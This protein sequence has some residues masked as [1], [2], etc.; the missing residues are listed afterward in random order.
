MN[1]RQIDVPSEKLHEECG[2]F[3]MY[4]NDGFNTARITYAG[5]FALQHRGQESSGIAINQNREITLY[6]N[7]GLVQEVFTNDIL[8]KLKGRMAI[9][10][11]RYS[12]TGENSILNAQPL[13]SRYIKG[14]LAMAANGNLSNYQE[15]KHRLELDGAIF[16]TT[17][18]TEIIMH[19]L[20]RARLKTGRVE[21]ALAEVMKDLKG[22]YSLIMMSPQK[23][24]ACRDP[25]GMRPLCIGKIDNSFV[26]AS[27]TCALD[28]VRAEF[29]REIDPGEVVIIDENGMRSI[30]DNCGDPKK[31]QIC[32]F[33]YI[34]FA[35]SDS[36]IEGMSVHEAR[37]LTGKILAETYR[38]DADLVAGVPDSGVDAAIGYAQASGIPY[39]KALVINRYVG[40]TFIQ[41]TQ[42]QRTTAVRL[43]INVLKDTVKGKRIVL[44]DDSI[45]RGTTCAKLVDMLKEA[46][47]KE[48]H[49]R[50]SSPPFVWPCYFGTDIPSKDHLLACHYSVEEICK[51]IG[52]D[53]LGFLP[54]ERLPEIVPNIR[55]KFCDGCFT[56]KY[57]YSHED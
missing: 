38:V 52:A 27:E 14:Q 48:V 2:V 30:R 20:A 15:L 42:E 45:V 51:M 24:I 8:E 28:T 47:A 22:S 7:Q 5:L 32:I 25:K 16:Q 4:D 34:Y 57:P 53:S 11:V 40:R 10:H 37:K 33:E 3:G 56:G 26:I 12:A 18:D 49:M 31:S 23:L 6:K 41:P 35:R 29:I 46:G 50:I 21:T 39:G 9:G 44:V 19:L 1:D 55:C 43:K 17:N 36:V 13:V 54:V